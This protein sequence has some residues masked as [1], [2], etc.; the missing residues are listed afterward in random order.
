MV[1]RVLLVAALAFAPA[2]AAA[3]PLA[4]GRAIV[5]TT[6]VAPDTHLFADPVVARVDVVVDP[7]QFDP[8][9]IQVNLGF[10]PYQLV[11]DLEVTRRTVGALVELRYEATLRCLHIECIA[12]RFQTELGD[13]EA[14]RPDRH[15]IRFQPAEILYDKEL[16]FQRPFPAVEVVSRLNAAQAAEVDIQSVTGYRASVEPPLATYQLPPRLLAALALAA[17]LLLC[18]FPVTLAGRWLYERWR[19]SRRPRPLSPLERALLL[20]A[21]TA[22][23]DDGERRRKALEA[24]AFVAEQRGAGPLAEATRALAWDQESPPGTRAE[25]IAAEAAATLDGGGNGRPA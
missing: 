1:A 25:E 7:A 12:P 18:A 9:R 11:G 15:A 3:E 20:V 10:E 16:L 22:R 8:D 14:D 17:A 23:Q 21:W 13:M 2:A 4:G 6:S 5:A 19:A 24:L